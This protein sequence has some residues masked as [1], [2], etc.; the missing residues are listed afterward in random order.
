[1]HPITGAF[2]ICTLHQGQQ[3]AVSGGQQVLLQDFLPI[4]PQVRAISHLLLAIQERAGWDYIIALSTRFAGCT[5]PAGSLA[6][7][8]LNHERGATLAKCSLLW[9][10]VHACSTFGHGSQQ[11]TTATMCHS[12]QSRCCGLQA[13]TK[14]HTWHHIS[15]DAAVLQKLAA[16]HC[17][18]HL[19]QRQ[20]TLMAW[21]KVCGSRASRLQRCHTSGRPAWDT[22][23][24]VQAN[25]KTRTEF[26]NE[27][28]PLSG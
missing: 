28:G 25:T 20:I 16:C 6:E 8:A 18:G 23:I 11:R 5:S 15:A 24:H 13:A 26:I 14:G 3:H 4:T 17:C 21:G 7:Q 27:G 1:M 19:R 12:A 2:A 9:T 22:L 10:A